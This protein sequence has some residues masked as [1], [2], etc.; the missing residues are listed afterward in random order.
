M[1]AG[2]VAFID[3]GGAGGPRD[4]FEV[5]NELDAARVNEKV[6]FAEG[7]LEARIDAIYAVT[8]GWIA[9]IGMN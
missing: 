2:G 3:F 9:G 1:G 6:G 4:V 7:V 8:D 5:A